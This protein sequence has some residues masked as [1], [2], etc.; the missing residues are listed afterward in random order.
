MSVAVIGFEYSTSAGLSSDSKVL[1]EMDFP[2][3]GSFN[4]LDCD[5]NFSVEI[6][7]LKVR[8][9][10]LQSANAASVASAS[11]TVSRSRFTTA[12][13]IRLGKPGTTTTDWC[14]TLP[15][16]L[17]AFVSRQSVGRVSIVSHSRVTSSAQSSAVIE[18]YQLSFQQRLSLEATTPLVSAYTQAHHSD[19][20]A[21]LLEEI[22]RFQAWM[23]LSLRVDMPP[24][25]CVLFDD[26]VLGV[27]ET[28]FSNLI[29]VLV[30]EF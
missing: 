10:D 23:N 18:L 16:D 13:R 29:K 8:E 21:A 15:L 25:F 26:E 19:T 9:S 30:F 17:D 22:G 7:Y 5:D 3:D 28:L 11:S 24:I 14:L 12:M 27:Y 6:E 4:N 20:T 2:L 1:S